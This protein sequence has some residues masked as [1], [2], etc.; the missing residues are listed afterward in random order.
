MSL[1]VSFRLLVSTH[2]SACDVSLLLAVRYMTL[3]SVVGRQE[4]EGP[5]VGATRRS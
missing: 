1:R 3:L 5:R 4:A 2:S